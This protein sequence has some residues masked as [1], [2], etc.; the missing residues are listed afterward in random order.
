MFVPQPPEVFT[1]DA[2]GNL[3]AVGRRVY[4]WEG[5]NRWLQTNA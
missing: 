4:T 3:T 5:E 2:D 1:Y